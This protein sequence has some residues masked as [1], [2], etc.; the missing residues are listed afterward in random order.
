MENNKCILLLGMGFLEDGRGIL[1]CE[2]VQALLTDG[3]KVELSLTPV[4]STPEGCLEAV[5]RFFNICPSTNT[6]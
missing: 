6:Q 3:S 2:P 4:I 1:A 5:K